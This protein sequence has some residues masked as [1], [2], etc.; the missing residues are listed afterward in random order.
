[1]KEGEAALE[2]LR[3]AQ[4]LF[5]QA[6]DRWMAV[7][8]MD[9]EAGALYT[10]ERR[11]ALEVA[12][13]ALRE[14]RGLRPVPVSTEVRILGHMGSIQLAHH[15]WKKAVA[16]YEE[17]VQAAGSL[18]DLGRL[19]RMYNDLS[20]AYQELGNLTRAA[21]Y[22][23]KALALA[24]MQQDR[25]VAA[26]AENNLGL[27]LMKQGEL[28]AAERHIRTS[29]AAFEE[30]Q[31]Q[32]EKSHVLLSLGQLYLEREAPG[33]AEA[34]VRQALDLARQQGETMTAGM[35]LQF[36]GRLAERAGD[37]PGADDAFNDAIGLLSEAGV[38]ER[39]LECHTVYAELLVKRGQM[40]LAIEH[41]RQAMALARPHTA[42]AEVLEP[43]ALGQIS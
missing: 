39:L 43:A 20:L 34:Y 33:P 14:C 30:V 8:C 28:D 5:R 1:L 32:R 38:S 42:P 22:S 21:T 31:V 9:W 35:A 12:E 37:H 27:V 40:D 3:R 23:H 4:A 16:A 25:L 29:L 15:E 41:W 17:A 10:L 18:R 36:L 19:A 11:E 24:A 7:E 2:N 13:A 26:R 6:G